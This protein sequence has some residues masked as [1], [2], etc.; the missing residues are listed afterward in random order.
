MTQ[1]A[2]SRSLLRGHFRGHYAVTTVTAWSLRGHYGHYAV[3]TVTTRS[4]RGHYGHYAVTTVTTQSERAHVRENAQLRSK[5]D[6]LDIVA[7]LISLLF[8]NRFIVPQ[9]RFQLWFNNAQ[10]SLNNDSCLP[11][12]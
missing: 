1:K 4:L 5:T 6:N 10:K 2:A 11:Q 12:Q 7:V 3:T 8:Q 9:F